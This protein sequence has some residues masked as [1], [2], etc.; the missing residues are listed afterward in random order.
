MGYDYVV[1]PRPDLYDLLLSKVPKEKIFLGRKVLSLQQ[2]NLGV[3]I[4]IAD[5]STFHGDILV[6]ADGAYSGVR[7]SL[8]K[9]LRK[10]GMLPT[11][12]GKQLSVNYSTLVGTT[13]AL[14]EDFHPHMKES[15]SHHSAMIG[16]GSPYTVRK[17]TDTYRGEGEPW[18]H[19]DRRVPHSDTT[20]IISFFLFVSFFINE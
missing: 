6:G 5:N 2:N 14:G 10:K 17:S 3:M 20:T 16:R 13:N 1:F 15:T 12:D 7:Q 4:R 19:C 18:E 11:N 8:F 9:E